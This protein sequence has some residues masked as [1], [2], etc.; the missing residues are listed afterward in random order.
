[1]Q[2]NTP[3]LLVTV[4][5]SFFLHLNC[6]GQT[7]RANAVH[8]KGVPNL[9][10]ADDLSD[11]GLHWN[12]WFSK[13]ETEFYYTIQENGRS[14]IVKR[15][16]HA[17][18]LGPLQKI[19]F[20][21]DYNYS[22]PWVSE[23]GTHMIFQASIPHPDGGRQDFNIWES[24]LGESGWSE[25]VLFSKATS[26]RRHE[27]APILSKSGNLY[28]NITNESNGNADLYVLL[29]GRNK[30]NKLPTSINSKSFEGDFFIDQDETF[31]IFSSYDRSGAIGQ[32]DLYVSFNDSGNWSKAVSLGSK[33]NSSWQE[34]SPFVTTD[35]KYLIFTSN[36]LSGNGL[37][38]T[39]DHYIVNFDI[40]HFR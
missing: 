26:T 18:G 24:F 19:P 39:F 16:V 20:N 2:P 3:G 31:L 1:M 8:Q 6:H 22:H 38:P 34:F 35:G 17:N 40:D 21:Q 33:I 27:G 28:F 23:D 13:N 5:V 37:R 15:A 32:S 10:F 4:L 12:N 14:F 11:G 25:P 7:F 36:R 29:E 9:L 30:A